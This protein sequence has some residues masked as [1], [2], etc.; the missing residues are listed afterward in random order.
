[1]LPDD[2]HMAVTVDDEGTWLEIDMPAPALA[3][4]AVLVDTELLGT[5]RAGDG[6]FENP[7]GTPLAIDRD[8]RGEVRERPEVGPIAGLVAGRNRVRVW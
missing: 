7:D 3:Q 4:E 1:M 8:L 5:T 2:P 6:P